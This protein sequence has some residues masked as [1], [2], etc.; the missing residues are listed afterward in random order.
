MLHEI[1]IELQTSLAAR[2]VP[3]VVVDGPERTTDITH[4]RQ[5]VVLER[6]PSGDSFASNVTP[7]RNPGQR[8][9]REVGCLLHIYAQSTYAGAMLFEHY[10]L[11]EKLLDFVLIGLDDVVRTR[12]NGLVIR[13]G[14]FVPIDD[15]EKSDRVNGVKY[16]LKFAIVRGVS[17]ARIWTDPNHPTATVGGVG[18]IGIGNTTEVF[19]ANG[20]TGD[21]PATG[22]GG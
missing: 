13:S 19:L 1:G 11:A 9:S 10:R 2:G 17:D 5:R 14:S 4:T 7:H 6:D 15:L 8:F 3:V 12:R 18:G 16:T 20:P 22:C 21:P